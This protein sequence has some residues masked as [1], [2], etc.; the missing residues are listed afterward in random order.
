MAPVL[1]GAGQRPERVL[2]MSNSFVR[3]NPD[4]A[5]HFARVTFLS[6]TREVLPFM[7]TPTLIIQSAHD[8]VAPLAVGLYLQQQL[9]DSELVVIETAGHCPHL[10]APEQTQAAINSFLQS[11]W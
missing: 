11:G 8:V 7:L 6:D 2:E 10:S 3:T 1:I 5:R 4:I 9:V